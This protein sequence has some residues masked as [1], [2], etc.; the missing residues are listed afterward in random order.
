M[1]EKENLTILKKQIKSIGWS[2]RG[3][4]HDDLWER[5]KNNTK[6]NMEPEKNSRNTIYLLEDN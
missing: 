2:L 3:Y 4:M 1:K 5:N 6:M